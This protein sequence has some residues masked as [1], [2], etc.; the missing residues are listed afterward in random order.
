MLEIRLVGFQMEDYDE[1]VQLVS[2]ALDTKGLKAAGFIIFDNSPTVRCLDRKPYP[3]VIIYSNDARSLYNAAR[4]I[5]HSLGVMVRK[6][7]C[8]NF[9]LLPRSIN[10]WNNRGR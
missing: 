10:R 8:K 9:I 5:H 2:D 4:A 3:H 7:N 6:E 1:L